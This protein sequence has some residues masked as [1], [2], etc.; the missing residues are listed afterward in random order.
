MQDDKLAPAVSP[1]GLESA[2]SAA[3]TLVK[4][5]LYFLA[6]STIVSILSFIFNVFVVRRLGD[7]RYGLYNTALAYACLLYTSPSPRD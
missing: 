3:A 2:Q 4:N 5:T 1:P 7:E 6:S